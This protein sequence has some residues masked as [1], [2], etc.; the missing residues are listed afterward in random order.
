M[1]RPRTLVSHRGLRHRHPIARLGTVGVAVAAAL[2]AILPTSA[3]VAANVPRAAVVAS[4]ADDIEETDCPVDVP[5]AYAERVTCGVLIVPERRT[6]GSDPARTL[7]LPL[8]V[9]ASRSPDPAGDPLVFPTTGGPGGGTLSALWY[10]LD[11]ADWAA[12]DRDIILIEQRGDALAQPSLDCPEL[13]TEHFIVDGVRVSGEEDAALRLE[14]LQMCRD[15][16]VEEGVDPAAYTSTESAADLADLRTVLGYD[17]WNLYGVSY[18]A[19]LA[20]TTM[21]DYPDGLR[22]VIL[23]GVYPPHVNRHEGT[24]AGFLDAV[25]R[26]F[27][28]CAAQADCREVYPDIEGDLTAVLDRAAEEPLSVTVKHPVDGSPVRLDLGDTELTQGLFDAFYDPEVIRALPFLI[29]RLAVGDAGAAVPLA[30]RSLDNADL[31]AEG[32]EQ[33]IECAEEVPFNTDDLIAAALT[34][35]PLLEHLALF[36]GVREACGVWA[37]P[38]LSALENEAVVSG[39]PTLL[40][41][42]GYDPITPAL[43]AESAAV[44]LSTHYLY[45]FPAMGHGSVW[46]NWID[47]CPASIAQQFLRDPAEEPDASCIS[48]APPDFLTSK[49]IQPTSALYRFDADVVRDRDPVA[50]AIAGISLLIFLATLIYAAAYGL[51]WLRTRRGEAPGGA[52]LAAATSSGLNLVYAGGLALVMLNTDP[53]ILAFGLPAGVWP[54][55]L[56]PF[57]AICAAILLIVLVTRAWIRDEGTLF[58]RVALSVSA[59]AS[60]VFAVWLL[61]RGLLLL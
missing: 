18:G 28:D 26:L 55:L 46:A 41:S 42:G 45:T 61:V 53:L 50:I 40:T 30:Q 48:D 27:A 2:I 25:N 32:L 4:V 56:V 23:D 16:L 31:R 29:D 3:A 52:V 39:I 11:Y 36:D 17:E 37:V 7:E 51:A 9:I 47:D 33:S 12:D 60:V 14:R 10:F 6:E 20:L 22:S 49:D 59:A 38:A 35:D 54:L 15:R 19:R 34:V 5:A 44:T 8:A 21:R 24:P 13:D 43:W 1:V 57:A 58:H